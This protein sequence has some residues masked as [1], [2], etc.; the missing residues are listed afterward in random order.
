MDVLNAFWPWVKWSNEE[1]NGTHRYLTAAVRKETARQHLASAQA[2][3]FD[4]A[5]LVAEADGQQVS[6]AEAR[7]TLQGLNDLATS[8]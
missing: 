6:V 1:D 3:G 7:A 4:D 2:Q 8:E 5:F